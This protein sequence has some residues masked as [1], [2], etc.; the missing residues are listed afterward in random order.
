[1]T[2]DLFE[3]EVAAPTWEEQY[4]AYIRSPKWRQLR[5]Q[6]LAQ[7]GE[8]CQRCGCSKWTRKLEVHHLHY[9][10]FGHESLDDLAV[11]CSA[12]HPLADGLREYFVGRSQ[13]RR[14]AER[15]WGP[16][17]EWASSQWGRGWW[18]GFD[19][20]GILFRFRQWL[21]MGRPT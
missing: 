8:R 12:C 1:M 2:V 21:E 18:C 17:H 13:L 14:Q 19:Q 7:V 9:N 15:E 4:A 3:N 6:K 10:S 11:M 5:R 20:D 16:F